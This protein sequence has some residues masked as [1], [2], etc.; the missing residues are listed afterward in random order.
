LLIDLQ[1]FN[2]RHDESAWGDD[3]P[4][5]DAEEDRE[6]GDLPWVRTTLGSDT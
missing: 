5:G 2:A 1:L 3:H 6:D 4:A